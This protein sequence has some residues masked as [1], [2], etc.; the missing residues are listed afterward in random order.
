[1]IDGLSISVEHGE[2]LGIVGPNGAGKTTWFNLVTGAVHADDGK[3]IFDGKDI[4]RFRGTIAAAR[5]S[6]APSRSPS[7]SRA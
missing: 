2:A 7:R 4:T 1:M 6:A 3:V 5:A